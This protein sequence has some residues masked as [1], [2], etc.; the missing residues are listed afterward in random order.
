MKT[1]TVTFQ[2]SR[3]IAMGVV[4]ARGLPLFWCQ[5]RSELVQIFKPVFYSVCQEK[6]TLVSQAFML[7]F[8]L[9]NIIWVFC[10]YISSFWCVHWTYFVDIIHFFVQWLDFITALCTF[11]LVSSVRR[12]W[13]IHLYWCLNTSA[14]R[15]SLYIQKSWLR[16]AKHQAENGK[17]RKMLK[18]VAIMK[19]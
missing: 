3:Q 15:P 6:N 7:L 11:S 9:C 1:L 2:A 5:T 18:L 4:L 13:L 16:S 19:I 8:S 17:Y 12:V 10:V 14:E